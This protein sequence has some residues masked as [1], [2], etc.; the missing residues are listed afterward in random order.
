[1]PTIDQLKEQEA[2]PAPVFLFDCVLQTGV[3]E[4]WSTHAVTFNSNNYAARL[5][6]HNL[7]VL[8]ASS[9]DGLDSTA[10]ISVTLANADSHFSQIERETGFKGGQLTIQLVFF[11]FSTS[12]PVSEARVIFRGVGNTADEIT[13]S[14]FRVT[15]NN[16]FNLQRIV[17]PDVRIERRCPWSFPTTSAQ[18]LEAVTG[19]AKGE[20][21][22]LYRCGYSPD[23]TGGVGTLNSGAP[24]TTC[25]F[26]RANCE[27][28]GM[29]SQD[30]SSNPTMRFG[31][32]EFVPAQIQV[33]SFGEGG[34]HASPL[35]DNLALY[36]DFVPLVYG[37]AWF[38]PPVVFARNDGNL[39][40]ME[41]LLGMGEID[42]IITVVVN[43]IEIPEGVTGVDMTATG[44]Y[45]V[46]TPGTR[47]G[48]FD[49]NFT[50]SSGNPLGDPYGSMAVLSVVVPNRISNGQ[51][52][53]TVQVLLRGLQL[54]SFDN[55]GASLGEAFTNNPAWV[56]LDV[57]RRSGWLPSDINLPSFA[58]AA[59]YCA[60]PLTT[61]DLYGNSASIS[62]FEC[63]LVVSDR[64]SAA[65]LLRGIRSAS[66][67]MLTYD[68]SGLLLLRVENTIALQQPDQLGGSNST[69]QLNDGWPAYEF[70]DSSATFSGIL[71]KPTGEPYLRLY[72]KSASD[73]TNQL[74][75]EFQD[76]FNDYQQDSLSLVDVDDSVLTGRV[77]STSSTSI[78]L[79]NFDQATRALQLQLAKLIDGNTFIEFQTT[80]RGVDL[81]PGDIIAVT[82]LKE[83]F[84]RQPF[85][86]VS[87]APGQNYETVLITAQWHD[88][89]WY[90]TGSASAAGG[91]RTDGAGVGIPRPLVGSTLDSNGVEQFG[92]AETDTP[93][94]D[95]TLSVLL[96]VAF[97]APPLVGA[98]GV[99]IP[100][101]GLNPAI[102]TTGG[103]LN[104]GQTIYYAVSAL[105]AT[106]AETALSFTI[107]ARLPSGTNTNTVTLEGLSF[108]PGTS[109]MNVYRGNNPSQMLRVAHNA[110]AA[111]TFLDSGIVPDLVGPPDAN[112][113]HAN[114]YWRLELQ[115]VVAA[116]IHTATT[117]GNTTLGMLP[118]DFQ[119]TLARIVSGTGATQERAIVSNDATTLTVTPPWTIVPDSTSQFVVAETTWKFG[120]LSSTSP[121]QIQVPDQPGATVEISGRSANAL[122]QESPAE[123][124]PFTRWQIGGDDGGG[125][126]TDTPPAPVFGLNPSGQ[127]NVELLG[128]GFTSFANTHTITAGTL[129]LFSWDELSSP[130]AFSITAGI[131]ATD[132]TVT[133]NTTGSGVVGGL[134][135][136]ESEVLEI[137]QV[138]GGGAQYTV[139]RGSHG[140]TAAG[141]LATALVY[142]LARNVS[143]VP[144]VKGFFGSE[145]SGSYSHQIFLPSV[146]VAAAE[147]FMTNSIGNGAVADGAFSGLVDDGIRT[148]SGGQI[149]I[150]VE[151]YL[152]IETDAAPAFVIEDAHAARD[153]FAV[154]TEAPSGGPVTLALRM[155]TTAYATLTIADGA[156]VSNTVSG[157]GL[158][159]LASGDR[160]ALDIMSVPSAT[161]TLPG[162]DL[163]V[164]IRL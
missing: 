28:R 67:L 12:L 97:D 144:F 157:F 118:N 113:D 96:A 70:S 46:V 68:S 35:I 151:G 9:D 109:G 128:I 26:T 133:L 160:L 75:V 148:L 64:T 16:R 61:T 21:S 5:L 60:A 20:Y 105:D 44:W 122:D 136:I 10:K 25:D 104:G 125:S 52:L 79:T 18:R 4:R 89:S 74:T 111:I 134:I 139:S 121:A 69:D 120:G 53:P 15:F 93:M 99:Q 117:I 57:L 38:Q 40:R 65:E 59:A 39:T 164:T 94:S 159:P 55:T 107:A 102:G 19:G 92:I 108:S 100:L 8:Q 84:E 130:T 132:V 27:A 141:H 50:D 145:A 47:S 76:E 116:D 2:T 85:R 127:G 106:G 37:T 131:S 124:N 22:A 41:V 143:I 112:Y 149:S 56:I 62:R 80:V 81:L 34:T 73:A 129:S 152:A 90:T 103:T 43:D 11:D 150:Q 45:N 153:I 162:R 6:R 49:L 119:G 77:V 3:V 1:M 29:F 51:S 147:F 161:G 7:F 101:V 146:R 14:T 54:E 30:A 86:I 95:G 110:T 58:T 155:G 66:S 24:F 137:T 138:L 23:Q 123:L 63:N 135:Q 114:F 17:L 142:H 158:P 83:G 82:Y 126:D 163:T 115:P 98:S 87:L 78:G 156:I 32:F 13:E 48:A 42:S 140:S 31:G 72:S 88:D 36:N 91:R 33:R 71:R 154:V